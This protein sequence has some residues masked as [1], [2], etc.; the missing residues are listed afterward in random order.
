M[1]LMAVGVGNVVLER[2]SEVVMKSI[3]S[4]GARRNGIVLKKYLVIDGIQIHE[5]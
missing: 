2:N 5:S 4:L 1:N 3:T